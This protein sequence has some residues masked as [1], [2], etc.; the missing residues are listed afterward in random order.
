MNDILPAI[1]SPFFS[2]I[3]TI[4]KAGAAK[5]LTP[6]IVV[7]IGGLIGSIILFLIAKLFREKLTFEKVKSNWKDLLFIMILRNLLGE[8]LFT[9]GLS[10]TE[11][12]KAIFFTKVEPFFVLILSWFLFKEKVGTKYFLLLVIHLIGAFILSTGGKISAVSKAQLGDLLVILAM[13][14]FASSY[15]F[16]KR[17]A[18]NV[19]STYSNAISMGM[20]SILLLPFVFFFSP[21]SQHTNQPQ[22]W[23]YLIIYVVLFNVISLTLWY[24]SLK[25]VKGWIVSALRYIGPI[26]GA[27]VAYLL[28]G[29]TL[30]LTQIF[31]AGIIIVTSYLIAREH[32]RNK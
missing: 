23:L 8:L 3:A 16:G 13:G 11:A 12:V 10:Q 24:M 28:F 7:A 27:P 30:S 25:S 21:L 6:L 20:A 31:G 26:L 14:F 17:L 9:F 29:E 18:H 19:G 15:S 1:L 5:S 32:F 4:F 22:G 2:S